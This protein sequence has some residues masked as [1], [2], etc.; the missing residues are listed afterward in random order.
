MMY[1]ASTGPYRNA[2]RQLALLLLLASP[3]SVL[4]SERDDSQI[5]DHGDCPALLGDAKSRTANFELRR[6]NLHWIDY[7]DALG[8]ALLVHESSRWKRPQLLELEGVEVLVPA[9]ESAE[10]ILIELSGALAGRT[11]CPAGLYRLHPDDSLGDFRV[12]HLLP[13]GILLAHQGELFFVA[14]SEEEAPRWMMAWGSSWELAPTRSSRSVRAR[15]N[16]KRR[17]KRRRSKRK[18]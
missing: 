4:A 15:R 9:P 2:L 16:E 3:S 11:N 13:S 14:H 8:I 5:H 17:S 18:R 7:D 6:R 1:R 12:L 10:P